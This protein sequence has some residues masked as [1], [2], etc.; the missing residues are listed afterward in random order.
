MPRKRKATLSRLAHAA[1]ARDALAVKRQRSTGAESDLSD[2]DAEGSSDSDEDM[3][4]RT[5][6]DGP[7]NQPTVI[8][9]GNPSEMSSLLPISDIP[10]ETSQDQAIR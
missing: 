4:S 8:E 5:D 3:E 9:Q 7:I 10:R 2:R 1:A 6:K